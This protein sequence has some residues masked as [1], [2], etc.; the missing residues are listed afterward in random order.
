MNGLHVVIDILGSLT[1]TLFV[2]GLVWVGWIEFRDRYLE[3]RRR[4][5]VPRDWVE[6][7]RRRHL[8]DRDGSER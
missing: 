4:R 8:S 1:L 7:E 6:D 3:P 5:Y 2:F